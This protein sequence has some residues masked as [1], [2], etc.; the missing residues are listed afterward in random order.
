MKHA[1]C[2]LVFLWIPLSGC[3]SMINLVD[4]PHVY[5][6]VRSVGRYGDLSGNLCSYYDLPFSAAL[7]TGLL[8]VTLL[9]E[10]LRGIAGWPPPSRRLYPDPNPGL[11]ANLKIVWRDLSSLTTALEL[12]RAYQGRYPA[13][14]TALYRQPGAGEPEKWDGI[15]LIGHGPPL[16]PWGRPYVYRSPGLRNPRG[17]DLSSDGPDRI[18]D[19]EDDLEDK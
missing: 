14:L 5:G 13:S 18:S 1:R 6:G 7:D 19:S 10:L 2:S 3:G 9:A 12:H 17:Y 8:P 11:T 15:Y 4:A 16:D